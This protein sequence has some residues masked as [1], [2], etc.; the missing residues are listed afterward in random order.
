QRLLGGYHPSAKQ[1]LFRPGFS[2]PAEKEDHD[3][4]GNK[5]DAHFRISKVGFWRCKSEIADS[6]KAASARERVGMNLG[7]DHLPQV[8]DLKKKLFQMIGVRQIL[9]ERIALELFKVPKVRAGA[10]RLAICAQ[11]NDSGL[12]ILFRCLKCHAKLGNQLITQ[13]VAL[14]R[15]V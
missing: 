13:R 2:N 9:F 3:D 14:L 7:D 12:L 6:R 1:Q 5:S 8:I 4:G 15:P 11:D 10:K